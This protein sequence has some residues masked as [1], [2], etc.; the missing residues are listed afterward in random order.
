M[1][2]GAVIAA[3]IGTLTGLGGTI[4]S[5]VKSK[6]ANK[7][8]LGVLGARTAAKLGEAEKLEATEGD[9]LKTALGKGYMEN[10]KNEYR[11]SLKATTESGLKKGLSDEAKIAGRESLANQYAKGISRLAQVGTQYRGQILGK[12]LNLRE[13]AGNLQYL[14]D[15]DRLDQRKEQAA[16]VAKG[17]ASVGKAIGD[18]AGMYGGEGEEKQQKSAGTNDGL[19]PPTTDPTQIYNEELLYEEN[20]PLYDLKI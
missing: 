17:M 3:I 10:L 6:E 20:E 12:G 1:N 7:A 16:N 19:V 4:Y 14:A 9:F 11:D 18:I 5:E 13:G 8:K 15:M 2:W